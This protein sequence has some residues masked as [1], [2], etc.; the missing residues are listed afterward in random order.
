V[1]GRYYEASGD[2]E[3]SVEQFELAIARGRPLVNGPEI[4]SRAYLALL[5][6]GERHEQ[7]LAEGLAYHPQ[8]S[9]LN[10]YRLIM[11][12]MMGDAAAT[13]SLRSYK[14]G[15]SGSQLIAIAYGVVA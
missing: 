10:V 1:S 14:D 2:R 3:V 8:H 13:E 4:Y 15:G 11:Q 5:A 9:L 6:E 7:W 12:S